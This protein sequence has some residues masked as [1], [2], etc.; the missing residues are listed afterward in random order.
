MING[1]GNHKPKRYSFPLPLVI[2]SDSTITITDGKGQLV[3]QGEI[4]I[5]S[6]NTQSIEFE[7]FQPETETHRPKKT[8]QEP[9]RKV[10]QTRIAALLD[11][12]SILPKLPE[13]YVAL[14]TE[15]AKTSAY[16]KERSVYEYYKRERDL[17]YIVQI[18]RNGKIRTWKLGSLLETDSNICKALREFSRVK[19]FYRRN[20]KP[21]R[22]PSGLKHGQIIKACLT[23]LT[24]E[25]FLDKTEV[26][27]SGR[28]TDRY[29]RTSKQLP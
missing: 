5:R 19:P 16:G 27:I 2:K 6:A 8:E 20:L 15:K 14:T 22:M 25:G 29:V 21:E 4:L 28:E 3:H 23:I 10:S 13:G 17:S 11:S 7:T 9:Q 24:H 1:N 12:L 18:K 26:Q